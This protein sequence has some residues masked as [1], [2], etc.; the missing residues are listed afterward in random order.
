MGL[1]AI[2]VTP[3]Q[4]FGVVRINANL[5]EPTK[6]SLFYSL[7]IV[8]TNHPPRILIVGGSTNSTDVVCM[9]TKKCLI[10]IFIT[11]EDFPFQTAHDGWFAVVV[12]SK[13]N[14]STFIFGEPGATESLTAASCNYPTVV[15]NSLSLICPAQRFLE[16]PITFYMS[17]GAVAKDSLS[18]KVLSSI[19]SSYFTI[20]QALP[21]DWLRIDVPIA[22]LPLNR[23]PVLLQPPQTISC[24][25]ERSCFFYPRSK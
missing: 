20:E 11:D 5:L 8:T 19:G 4:R 15:N 12:S 3:L 18:V 2:V 25:S 14:D 22:I 13:R 23:P 7:R 24:S 10:S 1:S 21:E 17:Y 16:K 6:Q 9:T